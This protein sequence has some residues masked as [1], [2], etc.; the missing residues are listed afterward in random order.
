MSLPDD[1]AR[2]RALILAVRPEVDGGRYPVKRVAGDR[3]L[4]EADIVGDGHDVMRAVVLDRAPDADTW[5]E[6]E[7]SPAPNDLW[8]AEISVPAIGIHHYTV[9]AWVDP[10]ATWRRGLERKLAAGWT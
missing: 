2:E 7:L 4:V 10:F 8:R 5:R 9:A 1:A 6:T 3:L